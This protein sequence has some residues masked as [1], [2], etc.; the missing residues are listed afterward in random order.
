MI[1][2]SS[3]WSPISGCGNSISYSRLN[4]VR[5][6]DRDPL[7]VLFENERLFDADVAARSLQLNDAR[8]LDRFRVGQRAAVE[9]RNLEVVEFDE[10]IIDAEGVERRKQMLDGGNP[11][12]AAHQRRRIGDALDRADI[13]PKLEVVEIDAPEDDSL[14]GRSRKNSHRGSARPV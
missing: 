7:A 10:G 1:S 14:S 8:L 13:R 12:A 9:N 3:F 2:T 5:R 6:V 4:V 11:D